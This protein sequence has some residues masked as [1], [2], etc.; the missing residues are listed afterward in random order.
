[1]CIPLHR[2]QSVTDAHMP[3]LLLFF[4]RWKIEEK[5]EK[6]AD[7]VWGVYAPYKLKFVSIYKPNSFDLVDIHCFGNIIL[8]VNQFIKDICFYHFSPQLLMPELL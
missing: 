8:K 7:S 4:C 2:S 1:M 6:S 5:Q 3:E